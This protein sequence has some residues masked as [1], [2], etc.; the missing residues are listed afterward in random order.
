[1]QEFQNFTLQTA[2][3]YSPIGT[4][5][6][7]FREFESDAAISNP[8]RKL[9]YETYEY[10]NFFFIK[11]SDLISSVHNN[12]CQDWRMQYVRENIRQKRVDN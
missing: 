5:T 2:S 11:M 3:L 4:H 8:F 12:K 10:Q 9:T 7:L 1:M 6:S